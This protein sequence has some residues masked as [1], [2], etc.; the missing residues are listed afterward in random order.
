MTLYLRRRATFS[1]GFRR[2][3]PGETGRGHDYLCE[4][5]VG[6][7]INPDT[8]MVLNIK[9]VDAVLQEHVVGPLGGT[10]LDT[11]KRTAASL[12]VHRNT[13]LYR[14]QRV[15]E[16]TGL[17]P[18]L[19]PHLLDLITA[20]RLMQGLQPQDGASAGPPANA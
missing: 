12:F 5:T 13:V 14:L 10:L 7:A 17:D 2:P 16:H 18:H 8:G 6:G 4:L 15:S 1:A 3:P 19:L 9:D 11:V 20:A